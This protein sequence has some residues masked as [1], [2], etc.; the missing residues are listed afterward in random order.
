MT[1]PYNIDNIPLSGLD[2][3]TQSELYQIARM[4]MQKHDV[5]LLKLRWKLADESA[6]KK[7]LMSIIRNV[8]LWGTKA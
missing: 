4:A 1:T 7:D 3:Y 2:H 8:N 6:T 5:Q